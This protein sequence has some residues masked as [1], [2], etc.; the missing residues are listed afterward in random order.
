MCD[1]KRNIKHSLNMKNP[2]SNDEAWG[3]FVWTRTGTD[4]YL[5]RVDRTRTGTDVY[6]A[7]VDIPLLVWILS[8]LVQIVYSIMWIFPLLVLITY[9]LKLIY[10]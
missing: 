9:L 5:P 4:V 10:L 1:G 6:F 2:L 3:F 8:P 7:C